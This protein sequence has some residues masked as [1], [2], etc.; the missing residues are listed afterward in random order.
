MKKTLLVM[1]ALASLSGPL[2]SGGRRDKV[3]VSFDS[4]KGLEDKKGRALDGSVKFYFADEKAPAKGGEEISARGNTMSRGTD[5]ERCERAMLAAFLSFQ[6]RA[7]K[8]GMTKVV[9]VKTYSE[10]D[11]SSGSR[12][13]CLCIAGG[14]RVGTVVKGRL[15]K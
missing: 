7:K 5:E 8:D 14:M 4:L 15:A 3:E 9:D 12:K 10:A 2:V 11:V 13:K 1:L 6:D